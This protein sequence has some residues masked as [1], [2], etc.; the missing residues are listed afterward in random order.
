MTKRVTFAVP[1]DLATPTGGYA[2]DRRMIAELQTLGWQIDAIDIGDCF[3]H[4]SDAQRAVARYVLGTTS[5]NAPLV[6]DG[7]AFGVIPDIAAELAKTHT[8]VAL[9]HHPLALETGVSIEEA[10]AL[11]M[12]EREALTH[13]S[14]VVVTSASTAHILLA[15]YGV[16]KDKITVAEPG[17]DAVPQAT[18]SNY[19]IVRLFTVGSIVPRKG[20]DVLV[21]T[22]A[23][24]TDLPWH[25]TIAG[26]PSR[27]P[28]AAAA[29]GA[30]IA[31]AGLEHRIS[32][33]GILTEEQLATAYCASDIFVQA[34]L[35]EGYG[36]AAASAI[37]HGLPI[38]ATSGGALGNTVG[39]AGLVVPP[40]DIAALAAALRRMIADP[41]ERQRHRAAS[42]AAA[43]K[44]QSWHTPAIQFSAAL[45]ITP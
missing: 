19:G 23:Q 27:D 38:V 44:L 4:P 29:L 6:I 45:E 42:Q 36:M 26:D 11:K 43:R 5:Q 37:A 20:Y 24:L 39:N 40:G 3:P 13:A 7:L 28:K 18:G 41:T 32:L 14:K 2:Y 34:S 16:P 21:A 25:L 17:H 30:A 35:F 9:V 22:L 15:D 33:Q 12:S 31:N 10:A 8:I 1:G